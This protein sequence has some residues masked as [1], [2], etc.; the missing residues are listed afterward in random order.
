VAELLGA[1]ENSVWNWENGRSSPALRFIPAI[2]GFL[3][4]VPDAIHGRTLGER[5]LAFRQLHGLTQDQLAAR[6]GVDPSTIASWEQGKHQPS[7]SLQR[8]LDRILACG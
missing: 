5:I 2:I 8:R 4:C 6:L 1:N 7:G 3:G